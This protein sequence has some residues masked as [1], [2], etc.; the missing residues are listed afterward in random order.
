MKDQ[1]DS[2]ESKTP[3]HLESSVLELSEWV[4]E[5]GDLL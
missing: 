3:E 4:E 5:H 2:L 1:A